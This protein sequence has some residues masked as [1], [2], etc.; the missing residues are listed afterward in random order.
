MSF[1]KY[2]MTWADDID[3]ASIEKFMIQNGGRWER[4]GKIVGD[5]LHAH[6][7][8]YWAELWPEDS[9]TWW[10]DLILKEILAN[11]FLSL[12]GPASSWKT[13]TVSRI[14]LMDWSC[15]P[16]CTT[17]LQSSTDMEGLRSRIFGETVKMY[18]S[19]KERF[20]WFPGFPIDHK[21]VI[22]AEDIEEEKARDLRNGIIGVP[23]KASS[24]KFLGMGKYS[25]RKNRRVWCISDEFQHMELSVLDAQD[26]LISNGPNLVPGLIRD[27][28]SPENG[29]PLRGYKAIF[30]AN[31]NPS[32][33]GNPADIVSEPKDGWG[34]A[35]DDGKTKV[36][37]CKKLPNHPVQCRCISL[38]SKD[39]PNTPYPI[40]K[41]MWV[42]LAG[43]HKLLNYTEGS[44]SYFSQGR[45]IF[46]FG[47]AAFK[48]I[49]KETCDQFHAFDDLIW[50]GGSPTTKIGAL[51]AAYGSLGSDRCVLGYMEFGKCV[52]ARIRIKLHPYWLVPIVAKAGIIPEDQIAVFC[53]EKME[54]VGV[55]AANFFFDARGSLA[56]S[57]ARIWSASVNSIEFGG[58]PTD[59]IAGPDLYFVDERGA[60]KLKTA[61]MAFVNFVSELWWSWRYV[62][63]SDQMRGLTLDVVFDAQPREW[64]KKAHDKIQVEPKHEMAKRTGV[65]PDLSD[66]AVIAIEGARRRG[67]SISKLDT[68][69][70]A[71]PGSDPYRALA[72]AQRKLLANQQLVPT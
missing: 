38:D 56:M 69:K 63:E 2:G 33:P 57:L 51:D 47:L 45:G 31:T 21:C 37:D 70:P 40:D 1:T 4:K 42:H 32:R 35:A 48:I 67:F 19:A 23:C 64:Y 60:R 5:G 27:P 28:N 13:G 52:D 53:K 11:Q 71:Q 14:A 26:N 22:C 20:D 62:I 46:K 61:R 6:F 41:P 65:S 25:G 34:V 66:M 7:K 50:D 39:S 29:K 17:I 44:E 3:A 58:I 15:F 49:T 8:R 30:I 24:G 55:P 18:R 10:T 72:L 9:Q 59:R 16:E 54:S 43:P 36:W 68:S 12:V